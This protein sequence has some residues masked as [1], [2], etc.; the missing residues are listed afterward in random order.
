MDVFSQ[1]LDS[2]HFNSTFYY[3]TNFSAPWSIQIPDFKQVARF[4]YVTQGHCWVHIGNGEEPQK[5]KVGDLIIIPHGVTHTL[6]DT[7]NA[8]PITLDEAFTRSN[9][10]GHGVFQYGGEITHNDTQLV[11]GNFEFSDEYKHPLIEYLPKYI[12]RNENDGDGYSWLKDSL[13][14]M[15]HIAKSQQMGINAIIKRLSE[16]IFIQSIRIWQESEQNKDGFLAALNDPLLSK[17]LKAFHED[18]SA[19]WSI[20]KMADYAGMS[21]SLF[22]KRFKQYL[23]QA[24]MQYVVM[25]RMQNAQRMLKAGDHSLEQV[26]L[27]VGYETLASFSKAFKRNVGINPGQY[28]RQ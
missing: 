23:N 3:T 10:E 21:R 25:W 11:C 27:A 13:R 5:L 19:P 15:G 26:A 24:P 1:I 28:R 4:H 8:P 6:S 22:A 7:P 14:F 16:I 17:G 9:Y 12:I 18:F 2:L 20:Q